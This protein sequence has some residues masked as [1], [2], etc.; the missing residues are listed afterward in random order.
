MFSAV[1][2]ASFEI[3]SP[4]KK[5]KAEPLTAAFRGHVLKASDAIRG[6]KAPEKVL[7]SLARR[8]THKDSRTRVI[9]YLKTELF[10]A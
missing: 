7:E 6:G 5:T 10:R 3:E 1:Y 2:D 8:T 4:L 9:N